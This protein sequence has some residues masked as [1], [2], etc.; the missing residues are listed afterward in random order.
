MEHPGILIFFSFK[1]V[2]L[3]SIIA[4]ARFASQ[5]LAGTTQEIESPSLLLYPP[6]SIFH[7]VFIFLRPFPSPDGFIIRAFKVAV[8]P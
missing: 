8:V 2:F 1:L 4:D 3:M 5:G 6:P 7:V